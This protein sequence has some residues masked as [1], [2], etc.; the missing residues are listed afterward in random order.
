M[1]VDNTSLFY[2][3]KIHSKL[4]KKTV[5]VAM[6]PEAVSPRLLVL[7]CSS[8]ILKQQVLGV[9]VRVHVSHVVLS[10][11]SATD[12]MFFCRSSKWFRLNYLISKHLNLFSEILVKICISLV[13]YMFVFSKL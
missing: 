8:A 4:K 11:Q 13:H 7:R 6:R 12:L 5:E 3:S 9:F 1:K 2:K 10:L